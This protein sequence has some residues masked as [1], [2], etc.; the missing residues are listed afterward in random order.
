MRTLAGVHLLGEA[1]LTKHAG[2]GR[3]EEPSAFWSSRRSLYTAILL[4]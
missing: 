1:G 4:Y 3:V 2:D